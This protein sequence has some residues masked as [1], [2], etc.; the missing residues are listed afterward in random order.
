[1]DQDITALTLLFTELYYWLSMF[2]MMFIPAGFCLYASAIVRHKN[3]NNAFLT[4]LMILPVLALPCFVFGWWIYFGF[5]NGPG[6]GGFESAPFA[7]AWH[8]LAGGF[9]GIDEF[10]RSRINGVSWLGFLLMSFT[11]A[12]IVAGSVLERIRSGALWML[13]VLVGSVL[14][15]IGAAWGWSPRGWMVELMGFHDAYAAGVVHTVAGGFA[16]GVLKNLGPRLAKV[17]SNKSLYN[18]PPH[19]I[20]MASF[21]QILIIL[22]LLGFYLASNQPIVDV[23]SGEGTFFSATNIYGTPVVLSASTL[24]FFM[25]LLAGMLVGYILS[26]GDLR[27]I[28]SCGVAG[29]V[30]TSAGNDYYHPLQAFLLSAVVVWLVFRMRYWLESRFQID[31][32]TSAVAFHGF[33][34]WFGLVIAGVVLWGYPASPHEGYAIINPLGQ[35]VGATILFWV[36]GFIPGHLSSSFLKFMGVLRLNP[37]IEVIGMDTLRNNI[38]RL[39][40]ENNSDNELQIL[41]DIKEE[42]D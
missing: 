10:G 23:Q 9:I 19:S 3:C 15:A 8:P 28:L 24:N 27:W 1:M 12:A 30:S 13:V 35:F 33:A 22:G 36:I 20:H 41:D 26:A 11:V 18:I 6:A 4:Q 17:S 5:V 31:D 38:S 25:S 37:D 16:L 39:E 21:G 7:V 32:V 34:G 40:S 42:K 29:I 14:W 2:L